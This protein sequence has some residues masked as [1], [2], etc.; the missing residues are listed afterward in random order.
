M[1]KTVQDIAIVTLTGNHTIY[2]MVS[3]PTTLSDP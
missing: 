3:F 2:R 1:S